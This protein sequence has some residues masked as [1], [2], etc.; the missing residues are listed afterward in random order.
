MAEEAADRWRVVGDGGGLQSEAACDQSDGYVTV[1]C[2]GNS[3]LIASSAR[4]KHAELK[5][6]LDPQT[7]KRI[8]MIFVQIMR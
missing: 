5:S 6:V 3:D 2:E 4:Q 1:I 7:K 8:G